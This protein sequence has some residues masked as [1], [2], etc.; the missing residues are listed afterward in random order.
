MNVSL[1]LLAQLLAFSIPV[2]ALGVIV[3]LVI[4]LRR[5]ARPETRLAKLEKLRASG[6]L[7]QAEYDRQR[8]TIISG[9]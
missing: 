1:T 3:G 5:N 8:A 2:L 4:Y 6:V 7:T 9:V